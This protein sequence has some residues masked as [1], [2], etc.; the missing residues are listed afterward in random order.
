MQPG[1][2]LFPSSAPAIS[3]PRTRCAWPSWVSPSSGWTCDA[4][5]V[6]RLASGAVPFFE[7]GLEELLRKNL[8]A[9]RLEFTTSTAA[10]AAA[11]VHFLCVGTPQRRIPR[12]PT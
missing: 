1:R 6:E 5:K 9:G 12:P 4:A 11:D 3:A 8:E 2:W 10:A 7:P